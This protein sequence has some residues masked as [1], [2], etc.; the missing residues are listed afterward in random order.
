V[1][2]GVQN[3]AGQGLRSPGQTVTNE[4][5][6]PGEL[7][8]WQEPTRQQAD[9]TKKAQEEEPWPIVAIFNQR[10]LVPKALSHPA[11]VFFRITEVQMFLVAVLL[12]AQN[13]LQPQVSSGVIDSQGITYLVP[14][15]TF[16]MMAFS[17]ALGYWFA[18]AG[19]LRVHWMVCIPVFALGTGVLAVVPITGLVVYTHGIDAGIEPFVT[20]T[21]L[22]LA[23]LVV[24]ALFWVWALGLVV[25]RSRS[26]QGASAHLRRIAPWHWWS[27]L[28]VLALLLLYY[29]LELAVWWAYVQAGR[30][31]TGN[32]FLLQSLGVPA[33]LLP[34]FLSFVLLLGS[35]DLLEWPTNCATR[36]VKSDSLSEWMKVAQSRTFC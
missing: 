36:L 1:L 24:L 34:T 2:P 7:A 22:R 32:G 8:T 26:K 16:M 3:D 19:A 11:L 15:V 30:E 33:L 18:L 29:A 25:V 4:I 35:T 12:F 28:G 6:T 31:A 17:V 27:F 9:K 5:T 13:S 20:E 23:Q 14:L 21:R 10:Y